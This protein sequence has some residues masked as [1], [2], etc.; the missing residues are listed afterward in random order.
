MNLRGGEVDEINYLKEQNRYLKES[1]LAFRSLARDL[2]GYFE[3]GFG[4][5]AMHFPRYDRTTITERAKRLLKDSQLYKTGLD[6][7]V[8]RID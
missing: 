7:H 3:E 1:L 5:Q 8:E 6:G 4:Y 2:L